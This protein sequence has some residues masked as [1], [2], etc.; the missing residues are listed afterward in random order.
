[1]I[2]GREISD[3]LSNYSTPLLI[4]S[5]DQLR[6][7]CQIFKDT[8]KRHF[9]RFNVF[10]SYKTNHLEEICRIIAEE[11]L[12]AEVVSGGELDRA[13][14]FNDPGNIIFSGIYQ[15]DYM[16]EMAVKSRVKTII[17]SR[18]N[19]I[20]RFNTFLDT[21][22]IKYN[23]AIRIKNP[24]HARFSGIEYTPEKFDKLH[25]LISKSEN[26]E[27]SM[28]HYHAGTQILLEKKR[29]K[30]VDFILEVFN[31]FEKEGFE[32]KELNLGGGFPEAEIIS[33]SKL[34]S[35]FASI[36]DKIKERWPE[37]K[38]M[39]EPGRYIVGN[40]GFLLTKVHD[41]FRIAEEDWVIVD[42]GDHILPKAAKSHFRFIFSDKIA[43]P[44]NN[45]ISIKGNLPTDIDILAKNY[46]SPEKIK[47]GDI[48]TVSNAGAYVLSWSFRFGFPNPA[49]LLMN[50]SEIKEIK[51]KGANNQLYY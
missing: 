9:S 12:G 32:I 31:R 20:S 7:N 44:Y 50:E 41:T 28:L 25:E 48:I 29:L 2:C 51:S 35:L 30:H 1:L 5:E 37:L 3:I 42:A 17:L 27:L 23:I 34:D 22:G 36:S 39:F 18:L 15:P 8:L 11:G 6:K 4:F 10:Y 13:L 43:E 16:L 47:V 49:I 45:R 40:T 38:I 14:K 46:P 21:F 24:D 26:L 33:D 19:Q